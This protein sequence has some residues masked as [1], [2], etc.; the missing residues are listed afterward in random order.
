MKEDVPGVKLMIYEKIEELRLQM[1]K[2][3]SDKA[4]TDKRVVA[5]SEK[6]DVLINEF[7]SSTLATKRESM[8]A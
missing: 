4:L 1:H 3:A 7:Y 6:L 5:I 2:I 8:G